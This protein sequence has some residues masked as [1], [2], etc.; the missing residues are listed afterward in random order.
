MTNSSLEKRRIPKILSPINSYEGAVGVIEA[1]ADEIYCGVGMPG[2]H[3][4]F[5]LQR[6][7]GISPPQLRTY[8]ELS[9]IVKYAHKHDVK[10]IL[11]ANEPF[12]SDRLEGEFKDHIKTCIDTGVDALIIGDIGV[13]LLLKEMDVNLPLYAST[14]FAT[15]NHEAVRFLE[16]LGFSRVILERHLTLPEISDVVSH[17]KVDIEVFCHGVGCSNINVNCYF[18]HYM[19]VPKL[20]SALKKMG[21]QGKPRI[22]CMLPYE[23]YEI[24]S[25][26]NAK[27]ICD[28]PILDAIT[29]CSLCYLSA[30]V[31][32]G[33]AGIKIVG[34]FGSVKSQSAAT[35]AYRELLDLIGSNQKS[36][37]DLKKKISQLRENFGEKFQK[38][39]CEPKRCMFSPLFNVPYEH[40]IPS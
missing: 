35:K 33:V 16:K 24:V 7:P 3:K 9:K 25:E 28:A 8:K 10:V 31:A 26:K 38:S 13:F 36:S 2:K 5:V 40:P 19:P 14:Y 20:L 39:F 18:Y 23:V 21:K 11:V 15:M 1:G 22:P 27:K 32:A 4:H 29:Y 30:L 17:S 6:G 34:R 37:R 12:M